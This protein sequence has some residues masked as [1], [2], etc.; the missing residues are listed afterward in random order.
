MCIRE[1][2]IAASSGL[3]ITYGGQ[4]EEWQAGEA[5]TVRPD[6][7]RF[8]AGNIRV[9]AAGQG[10][11]IQVYQIERGY[12]NPCYAG[13]LELRT[14]AEGIVMINELPLED[15]LCKVV[16][17]EMPASYEM[18]ALKA[19]AVCARSYAYRQAAS[20]GYPEYEAHMND[21]TDYQ[22]YNNSQ[23]QDTAAAGGQGDGRTG[24]AVS[25]TVQLLILFYSWRKDNRYGSVGRCGK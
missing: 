22:V 9:T 24:I 10:D 23:P 2:R 15:Y 12:G 3:H 20:Y 18:E 13:T 8:A 14:T 11:E 6:D 4:T 7:A 1:V 17:S 25:G 16:P 5:L 21:S 19:Q